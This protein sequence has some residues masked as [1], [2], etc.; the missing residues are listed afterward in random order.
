MSGLNALLRRFATVVETVAAICLA[1]VTI[2]IFVSAI[3]RYLFSAPI[4]DAFDIS[5][6]LLGLSIAWGYAVL[7]YRG[8]HI[9]VDLLVETLP[10][11]PRRVVEVIAQAI[12]LIFTSAL[13]WK[14]FDRVVS[15]YNSTEATSDLRLP[16][17]P[18]IG[19][20]WLGIAVAVLTTLA[21]LILMVSGAPLHRNDP[22]DD[23]YE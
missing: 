12:L 6:L 11:S 7:G 1:V 3:G 10:E 23:V 21:G 22:E 15:A 19:G 5:R 14:L 17:W 2:L 8:G 16:V 20:I 9:C 18:F 4:P 13:A